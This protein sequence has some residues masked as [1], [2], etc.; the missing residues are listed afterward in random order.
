MLGAER[1][2]RGREHSGP[3]A[4]ALTAAQLWALSVLRD[5]ER[6]AGEIADRTVTNPATITAM[7]DNLEGQGFVERRRST[8][9]RRVCLVSLTDRG[10]EVVEQ[11]RRRYQRLWREKLAGA[12]DREL[13][14]AIG[15]MRLIVETL[16]A[17]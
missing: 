1:R 4:V 9:D 13:E 8:K 10:H 17:S 5:G 2:L 6:T 16:D 11:K 15:V 7:L 12:E 14:A 3:H